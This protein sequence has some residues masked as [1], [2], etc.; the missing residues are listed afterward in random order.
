M[1]SS[2]IGSTARRKKI[3]NNNSSS[4]VSY[5]KSKEIINKRIGSQ[6]PRIL[7]QP[8][9]SYTDGED[10]SLLTEY[11]GMKLD[12]WQVLIIKGMLARNEDDRYSS[13]SIGIAV[14]RQNG[15]NGVLE[16]R[17][18]YG[19]YICGEKIL[20]TAHKGNTARKAFLRMCQIIES[21]PEL[22]D[23]VSSIHR[24]NGS[25]AIYLKNGA[26][27]E[28][29]SRTSGGS[30]GWTVNV[31]VFDEA[32]FL[33][34]EHIEAIMST[35]AAAPDGNRQLIYTGTPPVK[36]S[37]GPVFYRIREQALKNPGTSSWYEWSVKGKNLD[38]I[39]TS[40]VNLWY[41][42]NPALG[43]RLTEDFTREEFNT[44][45][46]DGFARERLG[47]WKELNQ[48]EDA[49]IPYIVWKECEASEEYSRKVSG[50]LTYCV[51]FDASGTRYSIVACIVDKENGIPYVEVVV[52]AGSMSK[53]VKPIANW[54]WA[55]LGQYDGLIV[56]GMAHSSSLIERLKEKYDNKEN[57]YRE[58]KKIGGAYVP[59]TAEVIEACSTL[60]D[61]VINKTISHA[62]Q[63][64][65]D[66]AVK[67]SSKR[68]I[69]N[70]G[71][72][73]FNGENSDVLEG[74]ALA[75]WYSSIAIKRSE[76]KRIKIG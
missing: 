48:Y 35:L 74:I 13:T 70:R 9:R 46:K 17:E 14:P 57:G 30:R 67:T 52:G 28:Y 42:T 36:Y 62:S 76:K 16:A 26:S 25:E 39:D 1:L 43:I 47:W 68:K 10:A 63:Q 2:K 69:G 38:D 65:S 7:I 54:L 20:H 40:D 61:S 27:I 50:S 18:L 75:R 3:K 19:M 49:V 31:V 29:T 60:F 55:R 73:G 41:D 21:N 34:D 71:G 51:R 4:N 56:D 12:D 24:S 33:K 22:L 37:D 64:G 53:G 59:K 44:L 15:K 66:D 45:S 72:W 32:G 11:Y 58:Y 8:T 23:K 6:K 5:K